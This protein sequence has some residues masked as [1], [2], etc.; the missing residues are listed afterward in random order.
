[1]AVIFANLWI[2]TDLDADV[3]KLTGVHGW[4]R[5]VRTIRTGT[6]RD[7]GFGPGAVGFAQESPVTNFNITGV[8]ILGPLDNTPISSI[9]YRYVN[10]D[11]AEHVPPRFYVRRESGYLFALTDTAIE[12][13][14]SPATVAAVFTVSTTTDVCSATA[15]GFQ[16]G[17]LV[18]VTSTTTRPAPL[19]ATGIYE[20]LKLSD[21][22]FMLRVPGGVVIDFSSTGTGTHT[23]LLIN[24]MDRLPNNEAGVVFIPDAWNPRIS[25]VD[26]RA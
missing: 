6:Y 26:P 14:P 13:P 22:A 17:D 23:A 24:P 20:V 12:E 8:P 10:P 15:H 5:G 16:T 21:N 3:I 19:T 2:R 4:K 9:N 11:E 7:T 18:A 1:M 25:T